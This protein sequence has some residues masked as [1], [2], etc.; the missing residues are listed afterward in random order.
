MQ[1]Y[2]GPRPLPP[3]SWALWLYAGMYECTSQWAGEWEWEGVTEGGGA[4]W[5]WQLCRWWAG[6]RIKWHRRRAERSSAGQRPQGQSETQRRPGGYWK[7]R[8][9]LI[10]CLQSAEN[11]QS[12]WVRRE[13]WNMG[14]EY[15]GGKELWSLVMQCQRTL[16]SF[17]RR[18]SVSCYLS[19]DSNSHI[20]TWYYENTEYFVFKKGKLSKYCNTY[21]ISS[22]TIL[23]WVNNCRLQWVLAECVAQSLVFEGCISK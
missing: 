12:Q 19:C 8:P 7:N 4:E 1:D 2:L 15:K 10:M 23:L 17:F 11:L 20:E 21:N 22:T 3:P 9:R 6:L 14:E 13:M 5:R 16:S 18:F